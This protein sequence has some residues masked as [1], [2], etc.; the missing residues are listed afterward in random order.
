MGYTKIDAP[1]RGRIGRRMLDVGNLVS[2]N[3]TLLATIDRYDPMYAY[4]TVGETDPLNSRLRKPEKPGETRQK[5]AAPAAKTAPAAADPEPSSQ[6]R[7]GILAEL[8]YPVE[9]GLEDESGYPH[10]G[11]ID[12]ADNTIDPG[13]GTL[14][15]R[16][17]FPNPEPYRLEPGR[18]ARIRVPVGTR[19]NALLVPERALASDQAGR[20]VLVVAPRTSSSTAP[21][22]W[23]RWWTRCA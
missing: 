5:D 2:P 16:G 12:F 22:R 17:V 8:Q 18:F 23:G 20:Y 15:V 1:I 6:F 19:S 14:L 13:T 9:M 4:F 3:T 10:Q 11:H 7:P 21:S